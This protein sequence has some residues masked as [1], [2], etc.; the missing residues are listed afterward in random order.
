MKES[1]HIKSETFNILEKHTQ[2]LYDNYQI[3]TV[4]NEL[5]MED[6]NTGKNKQTNLNKYNILEKHTN[7]LYE[8][9]MDDNNSGSNYN[10]NQ[11]DNVSTYGGAWTPIITPSIKRTQSCSGSNTPYNINP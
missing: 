4:E 3:K 10:F 2:K 11:N 7:K 9:Y 1:K 8:N 6:N 5:Y